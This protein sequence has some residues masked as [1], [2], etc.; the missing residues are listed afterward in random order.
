MLLTRT[1]AAKRV[2]ATII[3]AGNNTDGYKEQGQWSH[4]TSG[5]GLPSCR[6]LY[7]SFSTVL[8]ILEKMISD[9]VAGCMQHTGVIRVLNPAEPT[10]T[11][12]LNQPLLLTGVKMI[13]N[14][15]W[16]F[17]PRDDGRSGSDIPKPQ[18]VGA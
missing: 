10:R 4:R 8:D 15:D 6:S 13:R 16:I 17:E 5:P 12:R 18:R 1:S 14:T 11:F 9:A 7:F 2:Y 3:N